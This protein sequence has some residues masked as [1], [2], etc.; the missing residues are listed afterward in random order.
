MK[1]EH[2]HRFALLTI[3]LLS[4]IFITGCGSKS[5]AN[6]TSDSESSISQSSE[7]SDDSA[8]ADAEWTEETAS[9]LDKEKSGIDTDSI[10]REQLVE[11]LSSGSSVWNTEYDYTDNMIVMTAKGDAIDEINGYTDDF[12]DG[13]DISIQWNAITDTAIELADTIDKA[14]PEIGVRILNP[15]DSR[16]SLFEY[17]NG[18][19]T[20]DFM[21]DETTD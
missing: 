12:V 10:D 15:R 9:S 14:I 21:T 3:I 16:R 8:D 6:N 19:V 17:Q 20:Y 4:S 1:K 7:T 5:A 13:I 11:N 18:S 2:T